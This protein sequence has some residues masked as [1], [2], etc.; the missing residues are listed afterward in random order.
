MGYVRVSTSKQAMSPEA[1]KEKIQALAHLQ[2]LSLIEVITD[3]ETAKEGSIHKRAGVMRVLEMARTHQVE[4]IVIA[5]LDR[6]TRSV[7]DLGEILTLLDKHGTA[8]VSATES[9]MDTGSAAG[10]MI[11]NI[12]TSVAQWEREAIAERTSMVLQYKK[13]HHQVYNAEP[14]GWKAVGKAR[15]GRK[16]AGKKLEPIAAEQAVLKRIRKMRN[17]GKVALRAI[18]EKLNRERVPTKKKGGRWFASTVANC[19][20]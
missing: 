8:L 12:V 4:R 15:Y 20:K 9:W 2:D 19:L 14:Y 13:A 5:K 3:R 10:R 1:Q 17:G 7:V 6:L 16:L 11:L 18:A